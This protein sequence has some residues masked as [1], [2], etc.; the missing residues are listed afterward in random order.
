MKGIFAGLVLLLATSAVHA[1]DYDGI[2][3]RFFEKIAAHQYV[4]AGRTLGVPKDIADDEQLE[5]IISSL[6][7]NYK[8]HELIF[9]QDIGTRVV[10]LTYIVGMEEKPGGVILKMYKPESEWKVTGISV[11]ENYRVLARENA[12][13]K[14]AL[15]KNKSFE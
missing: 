6:K 1:E 9:T 2:P 3:D 13:T 14:L 12:P 15:T 5:K 8:Y 4:D 11:Y 7:G 10:N